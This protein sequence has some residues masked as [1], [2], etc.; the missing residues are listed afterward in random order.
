MPC[1]A[2]LARLE[3]DARPS[4]LVCKGRAGISCAGNENKAQF[5]LPQERKRAKEK[6]Q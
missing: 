3:I 2:P 6:G 4:S 1:P 5:A